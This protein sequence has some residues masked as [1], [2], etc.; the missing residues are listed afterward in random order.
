[1]AVQELEGAGEDDP[2]AGIPAAAPDA[3]GVQ[4][5]CPSQVSYTRVVRSS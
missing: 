4:A 2:H 3:G 1:M 5:M